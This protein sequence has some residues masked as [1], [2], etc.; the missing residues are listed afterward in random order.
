MNDFQLAAVYSRTI[1][2]AEEFAGKYDIPHIFTDLEEMAA[3]SEID[4]VYIATL[5]CLSC[6]TS[7]L[8]FEKLT[9]MYCVKTARSQ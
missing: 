1:E 7:Y 4:A 8:I 9:S 2:K 5:K 6:G 3:S